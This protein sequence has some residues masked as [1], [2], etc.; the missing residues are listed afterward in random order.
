MLA[1]THRAQRFEILEVMRAANRTVLPTARLAVID[2]ETDFLAARTPDAHGFFKSLYRCKHAPVRPFRR[3]VA[4]QPA[5]VLIP[6][7]GGAARKR[8]PVIFPKG[9]RA[10][11]AAPLA[12]ASREHRTAPRAST[13]GGLS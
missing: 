3:C 5:A 7:F 10:F 12:P 2:F 13:N 8:P 6:H 11:L 9:R 1:V 4:A